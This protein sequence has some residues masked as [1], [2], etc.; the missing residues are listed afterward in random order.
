MANLFLRRYMASPA[1]KKIPQP[2]EGSVYE[3][4]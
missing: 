1:H 4:A 2:P 3:N